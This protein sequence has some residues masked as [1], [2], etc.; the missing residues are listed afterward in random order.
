MKNTKQ[1]DVFEGGS[2]KEM[3][4]QMGVVLGE[5]GRLLQG[6]GNEKSAQ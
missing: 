6:S 3:T 4:H 1:D 2:E 5:W